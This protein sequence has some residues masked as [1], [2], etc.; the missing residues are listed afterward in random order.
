MHTQNR[1]S[2][3]S[4][5]LHFLENNFCFQKLKTVMER[6][7]KIPNESFESR[8]EKI[9]DHLYLP[10]LDRE[11]KQLGDMEYMVPSPPERDISKPQLTKADL[12]EYA[13]SYEQSAMGKYCQYNEEIKGSLTHLTQADLE[14]YTRSYDEALTHQHQ[15]QASYAQSEGYHSYVSSTDSTSTPFLDR[16][17][18]DSDV[19][20]SRSQS[21]A[22][23]DELSEQE[24]I[25]TRREGRDSVVTTSSGSASS[26]ETLKWHGSMSDVSVASSSCTLPTNSS[27]SS[28]SRQ[29]I[30][31][32]ARVQ[33]PQKHHSESVLYI[34]TTEN[35]T[36]WKDQEKRNNDANKLKLFPVNTYTVELSELQQEQNER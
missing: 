5:Y 26:S 6:C 25:I 31:H 7:E 32:S 10:H 24:S 15:K 11:G 28:I 1:V 29:L 9:N 19:A 23:W 33:T 21:T 12:E 18:R 13:R 36:S 20:V 8:I 35:Q 3:C 14:Q 27:N 22:T 30:A 16:L 17:R 4:F 2:F 34:G